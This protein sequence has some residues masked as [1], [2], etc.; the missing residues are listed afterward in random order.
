MAFTITYGPSAAS[1]GSLGALIGSGQARRENTQMQNG[2]AASFL[3]WFGSR[4]LGSPEQE[5]RGARRLSGRYPNKSCG[6]IP[7]RRA[8]IQYRPPN[9]GGQSIDAVPL[10]ANAFHNPGATTSLTIHWRG[11]QSSRIRTS[12]PIKTASSLPSGR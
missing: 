9:C 3:Q 7:S 11:A 1:V 10:A 12:C 2:E 6:R 4:G 5:I 8:L